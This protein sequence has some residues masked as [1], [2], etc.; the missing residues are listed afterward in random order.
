MVIF[1]FTVSQ[2]IQPRWWSCNFHSQTSQFL[3]Q[4]FDPRS[5][6]VT[7]TAGK[8]SPTTPSVRAKLHRCRPSAQCRPGLFLRS[9]GAP[10][11]FA[12]HSPGWFF[13]GG[14]DSRVLPKNSPA[15]RSLTGDP[16]S[17]PKPSLSLKG[18][19]SISLQQLQRNYRKTLSPKSFLSHPHPPGKTS[20][21][22]PPL[23]GVIPSNIVVLR[24]KS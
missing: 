8:I 2:L 9:V 12:P 21:A 4:L 22:P 14:G 20:E 15:L 13:W 18:F 6:T 11:G 10:F 16:K 23:P 19:R 7:E 5:M 17:P 1:F 24:R 3:N